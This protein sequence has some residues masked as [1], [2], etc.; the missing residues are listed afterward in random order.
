MRLSA[1]AGSTEGPTDRVMF[2]VKLDAGTAPGVP[3]GGAGAEA[4]P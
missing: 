4:E 3:G 2:T 1:A